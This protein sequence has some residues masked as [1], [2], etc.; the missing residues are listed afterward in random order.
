[1][2]PQTHLLQMQMRCTIGKA[3]PLSDAS[4]RMLELLAQTYTWKQYDLVNRVLDGVT[5]A[6]TDLPNVLGQISFPFCVPICKMGVMRLPPGLGVPLLTVGK[7]FPGPMSLGVCTWMGT[8]LHSAVTSR[9]TPPQNLP[10][11]STFGLSLCLVHPF[12]GKMF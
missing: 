11:L 7:L 5:N 8:L 9:Q 4:E 12:L 10:F 3:C 6:A 1:M 2:T